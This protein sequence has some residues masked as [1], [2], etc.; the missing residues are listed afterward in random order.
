MV[1]RRKARNRPKR[2]EI[3]WSGIFSMRAGNNPTP[4][5][6]CGGLQSWLPTS[7]VP[8]KQHRSP[9][10]LFT[11]TTVNKAATAATTTTTTSPSIP[12]PSSSTHASGNAD[13]ETGT[14][15]AT[16]TTTTSGRTM[17]KIPATRC[18]AWNRCGASRIEQRDASW[19][20]TKGL[21]RRQVTRSSSRIRLERKVAM[22]PLSPIRNCIGLSAWPTGMSSRFCRL[23]F[24]PAW[25]HRSTGRWN[26][27]KPPH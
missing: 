7:C 16:R 11:R 23:R 1:S 20:G 17:P 4:T 13:S 10:T 2:Q 14:A 25:A 18:G 6:A 24:A 22:V 8:K 26:I 9:R 21:S 12:V 15:G 5:V 27:W 3:N 19:S